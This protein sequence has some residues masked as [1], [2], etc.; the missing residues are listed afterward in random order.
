[1]N[2]STTENASNLTGEQ[3]LALSAFLNKRRYANSP[4][5]LDSKTAAE[6]KAHLV[7]VARQKHK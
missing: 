3:A 4:L 6:R 7:K 5:K 1:M 2:K